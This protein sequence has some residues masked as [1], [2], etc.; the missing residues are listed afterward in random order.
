MQPSHLDLTAQQRSLSRAHL[1]E[2][3]AAPHRIE[4]LLAN[5]AWQRVTGLAHFWGQ[6]D[7]PTLDVALRDML[8][9]LHAMHRAIQNSTAFLYCVLGNGKEIQIYLGIATQPPLPDA[10]AVL[11]SVVQGALPGIELAAAVA[12][13]AAVMAM[14]S[15][16]ASAV[17]LAAQ[18]Q[19]D[20]YFNFTAYL[21]GLPS[22][23]QAVGSSKDKDST[24]PAPPAGEQIER[25]IRGMGY[26]KWGYLVCANPLP[27]RDTHQ[28]IQVLTQLHTQA[29]SLLKYSE[30]VNET[31]QHKQVMAGQAQLGTVATTRSFE[32]TNRD[33]QLLMEMLDQQIE[34][35]ERGRAEGMWQTWAYVFAPDAISVSRAGSL[36]RASFGGAQSRPEPLRVAVPNGNLKRD[37]ICTSLTSSEIA[38]L[39]A[40]PQQ[41][42][43]GYR[44][45]DYVRFDVDAPPLPKDGLPLGKIVDGALVT[46]NWFGVRL[47][48]LAKHALVVGVTGSGKTTSIFSLLNRVW[49]QG[50]PFLIIE[51]AKTEYRRLIG[52]PAFSG[53]RVYTLGD[54]R[55]APF[56][57]NPFEFDVTAADERVRTHVQ[58]HI[59]YLKSVFNAAFVLYAPMPYILDMALHEV[60]Q[61]KG[62]DLASGINLR[63][64][65]Y[66]AKQ[67]LA[68]ER[69]YPVFPTL[70]DLWHKVGTV[71]NRTDYEDKIKDD[72]RAGLQARIESL[73]LGSKGLMLDV[74]HGIDIEELLAYPTVLELDRIGNDDEKAFIIGLLMARLCAQRR[75]QGNASLRHVT[76][77]E[78]AHRLLKNVDTEVGG[79]EANN[80]AAS[81]EV[82]ANMLSEIRAYGEGIVI[83]EQIPAKLAP[84]AIKNTNLKLLHRMLAED[85]RKAVGATINLSEAQSRR[86]VALNPQL[87]EVIAY[88]EGNDR[89]Y[90]LRMVPVGNVPPIGPSDAELQR[91][92]TRYIASDACD[93][94]PEFSRYVAEPDPIFALRLRGEALELAK[95]PDLQRALTKFVF[96]AMTDPTIAATPIEI[97]PLLQPLRRVRVGTAAAYEANLQIGTLVIAATQMVRR[98]G[99]VHRASYEDSERLRAAWVNLVVTAVRSITNPTASSIV[100]LAPLSTAVIQAWQHVTQSTFGPMLGC[101]PCKTKCHYR[102]AGALLAHDRTIV[103]DIQEEMAVQGR[104]DIDYWAAIATVCLNAAKTITP[105]T[106]VAE[107]IR[108]CLAAHY[109]HLQHPTGAGFQVRFARRVTA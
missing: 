93:P 105:H 25:L 87:G 7:M 79:E 47:N 64:S 54:E 32:R 57:L 23:K 45:P 28:H 9:G 106:T 14:A 50:K 81:V 12:P 24:S 78:E 97:M 10:T 61:D 34:R 53:L 2:Q 13:S 82:F 11:L 80:K 70:T 67:R 49:A 48:D 76:V 65:A 88:A 96:V 4:G 40:L 27:D 51:P 102:L 72:V 66:Q 20:G 92:A 108:T 103:A 84:D 99:D 83:A 86:A 74:A 98:M 104:S 109:G 43:S 68:P 94:V 26:G 18:L 89:P 31:Q 36:L 85:D 16:P 22:P 75:L 38:G 95:Q 55:S 6:P 90:L 1:D 3:T 59:D 71:I 101:A 91:L 39:A 19:A 5:V 15:P 60:Y 107:G 100:N 33:A 69:Q 35:F 62:W 37:E 46:A 56:R 8:V 58:T 63:L 41:E 52:V 44:V 29:S 73:R 30:T 17:S 21:T 77:I 42:F